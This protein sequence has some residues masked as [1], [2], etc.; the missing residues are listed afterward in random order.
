MH[1]SLQAKLKPQDA[2]LVNRPEQPGGFISG[3]E[4]T[5][6]QTARSDSSGSFTERQN[7]EETETLQSVQTCPSKDHHFGNI[8]IQPPSQIQAKLEINEPGDAYEQEADAMAERVMQTASPEPGQLL[9]SP[10]NTISRKCET[11]GKEEDKEEQEDEKE[12][13]DEKPVMRK[14]VQRKCADCERE[15]EDEKKLQR[16]ESGNLNTKM[17]SMVSQ[18]LQSVGQP[19]DKSIRAFM[20]PHFGFD[21]GNVQVHNDTQAHQSA[22]AINALAYTWNNR[23][24]FGEG[25]YK[26]HSATGKKLLAHE[27]THVV[28]QSGK[29]VNMVQRKPVDETKLYPAAINYK[30]ARE[31]NLATWYKV[32]K[33]YNLFKE[34]SVYPG[35]TPVAYAN[36]VYDLQKKLGAATGFS[37]EEAGILEEE[38]KAGSTLLELTKIAVGY[39]ADNTKSFGLNTEMLKRI[40]K[41]YTGHTPDAPPLTST[42]FKGISQLEAVNKN[43]NF[44]IHFDDRGLYVERLQMALS[45]L[46]Y[47]LGQDEVTEAGTN[48]KFFSSIYREGTVQAV[49][50]F[51]LDSGLE[52]KEADGILGQVTL[53]LLDKRFEAAIYQDNA[54]G[55]S[56]NAYQF[57]IPLTESDL[58]MEPDELK[59]E[60]L[61]RVL[62]IA[63]PIDEAK[64]DILIKSG[65]HWTKY[66]QITKT[67]TDLGYW[68]VTIPKVSY[69]EIVR[70]AGQASG[71]DQIG[72]KLDK[73]ILDLGNA[74]AVYELDLLIEE[75]RKEIEEYRRTYIYRDVEDKSLMQERID[76]KM[77]LLTAQLKDLTDRRDIEL[78]KLG[79]TADT[80]AALKSGFIETF[81]KFAAQTAFRMLA[82][83]ELEANIEIGHYKNIEEVKAIKLELNGLASK[84]AESEKLWWESVSVSEGH[85]KTYY[86][87]G[88]DYYSKNYTSPVDEFDKGSDDR[89]PAFI[90]TEQN[91]YNMY[92][93]LEEKPV[94]AF[95]AWRQK[96]TEVVTTILDATKKFPILAYPKLELRKNAA[97]E[98]ALN[99]N[100]LQEKLQGILKTDVKGNIES[101]RDSIR[102]DYTS[103]WKLPL[104]IA[105]AKWEAHIL[106]GTIHDKLIAEKMKADANTSFWKSIGL[107]VLGIGLGLLALASGPVGWLALGASIAVGTYDAYA[108]Y[109]GIKF[110]KEAYGAAIDPA[111]ALGTEDPSYFWAW[112]SVICV[113][114]DV[115]QAASVVKNI[116]KAGGIAEDVTKGLLK[117]EEM[118]TAELKTIGETSER[119]KQ[120]IKELGEI[121]EA[122]PKVNSLEFV[123]NLKILESLKSN[124]LAVVVM[125]EALKDKKIVKAVV[126][127]GKKLDKS[128]FEKTIQLYAGAGRKT[129]DEL[130]ELFRI[131]DTA[132]LF[133]NT[134]LAKDILSDPRIQRV[135]LDMQDTRKFTAL[136]ESWNQAI[137]EGETVSFIQFLQRSNLNPGF[138]GDVKL[139]EMFGEEFSKLTTPVKNR[140]ILNTIEPGLLAAFNSGAL[141]P[142]AQ[143]AM[144]LLINSDLLA[145]SSRLSSAQARLLQQF[146]FMGSTIETQAEFSKVMKLMQSPASRKALWDGAEQLAGKDIYWKLILKA[147]NDIPPAGSLLDDLI[148]IGPM[149][150]PGTIESLVKD[151]TGLRQMLAEFPEA[152]AVLKK[153]ASPCLP[154]FLFKYP[155]QVRKIQRIM[156]GSSR[157]DLL[158]VREY[159]YKFRDDETLFLRAID[160]MDSD[161]KK[162]L[163][164]VPMPV[165]NKPAKLASITDDTL[166]SITDL[167]VT[168]TELDKI[169]AAAANFK[170]G[171][172][173]V[174][175]EFLRVLELEKNVPLQNFRKLIEGLGSLNFDEF[176]AA[177]HILNDAHDYVYASK[178]GQANFRYTGL[179]KADFL[180]GRFSWQELGTL[181]KTRWKGVG[182]KGYGFVNTL[183]DLID[184]VPGISNAQVSELAAIAGGGNDLGLA[185]DILAFLKK[186]ALTFDEAVKAIEKSNA[187]GDD[188][189]KA[190]ADPTTGYDALIALVWG[191][192]IIPE[193]GVIKVSDSFAGGSEAFAAVMGQGHAD[194]IAMQLLTGNDLD[195]AKWEVFRKVIDNSDIAQGIKNGI[196]GRMW[197]MANMKAFKKKGFTVLEEKWLKTI[198]PEAEAAECIADAIL[199]QGKKI[200]IVEFKSGGAN[201]ERGQKV[202]YPLLEKGKFK[203]VMAFN[204]EE[205]EAM[206]ADP[207]YI[208]EFLPIKESEKVLVH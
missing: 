91:V 25:Q 126:S 89:N 146:S 153:C 90:Y 125:S 16:K 195:L 97:R 51:Q 22:K 18:T 63:F 166:R 65:W 200:I 92:K 76:T 196:L 56:G 188:V 151:T 159:L 108:T 144:D 128:T 160:H 165:I 32:Y 80:F 88:R 179:Q 44:N 207:S 4:F 112:V 194:K 58:M 104:V 31:T 55:G 135:L 84:Y 13:T 205:L 14:F 156:Q 37:W 24:V 181:M 124:P 122:M 67:D 54:I 163:K 99:D 101:I 26:P 116:I 20:E 66:R 64:V 95:E 186:P 133:T 129:I 60:L 107:A 33:F 204:D 19:L 62:R 117:A 167:G 9:V 192:K 71:Q 182:F 6:S 12:S 138:A 173:T 35:S 105:R 48:I 46:N 189:A 193:N 15:D 203:N 131:M 172:E 82:K 106:D 134:A 23:I 185:K 120:I 100:V 43:A 77:E 147:N 162:A 170:T 38:I 183:Y 152:V 86:Q 115:L 119:G 8:S 2:T 161:L 50:N 59:K 184:M 132:E 202:I 41:Y 73:E 85:D 114:L 47:H 30:H 61:K 96:E 28:Q 191:K 174:I 10:A 74:T 75:K 190:L 93:N 39:I 157:T 79:L 123:E 140:Y 102:K 52:G 208:I 34:D 81:G 178:I 72:P 145:E 57:S 150:D 198:G 83:N 42:Y 17:S 113:G 69:D 5:N 142:Q 155:E 109:Q 118:L 53:R 149:T 168:V 3:S 127:L 175:Y 171:G 70:N 87:N 130:P 197:G 169:L 143:K 45:K 11:C 36:H 177:R 121:R 136:Y 148:R 141:P 164:D 187:F 180:L 98:A 68:N 27:L 21:F 176:Q 1:D 49:R 103:V 7:A 158:K 139:V 206:F 137:K 94:P 29:K 40:N 201:Y 78:R 110:E 111:K 154:P 199:I